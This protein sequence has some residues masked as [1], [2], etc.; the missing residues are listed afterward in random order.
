MA[1]LKGFDTKTD[2]IS[3]PASYGYSINRGAWK[4]TVGS[5]QKVTIVVT[6]NSNPSTGAT[7]A[8][9]GLAIYFDDKHVFTHNYF[10]FRNDAKVDVSSIFFSTFFGGSSAEYASKGGYAYFRNM[11]SYYSTAAATASGA[12][13]TAIY[14]S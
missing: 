1:M 9:G 5:W 4:F 10:V 3:S 11:K 2:I 12:M 7:E 14:P 6:L 8:N 13:V